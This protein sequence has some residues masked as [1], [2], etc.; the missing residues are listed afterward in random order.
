MMY[1][2]CALIHEENLADADSTSNFIWSNVSFSGVDAQNLMDSDL[3]FL[4][5]MT[6]YDEELPLCMR[7]YIICVRIEI[8]RLR[9]MM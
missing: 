7:R 8:A 6:E 1:M 4:S 9:H 2:H 3:N 5:V